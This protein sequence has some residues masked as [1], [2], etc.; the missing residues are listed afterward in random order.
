[1]KVTAEIPDE[2]IREAV[3][4]LLADR[5]ANDLWRG[6]SDRK[7][8]RLIKEAVSEVIKS[9]VEDL[10]NR[11]VD[12]AARSIEYRGVKKLMEGLK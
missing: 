1:M 4:V 10:T 5:I 6:Y 3:K 8:E 9:N 2:E 11:A 12:A 7:Y